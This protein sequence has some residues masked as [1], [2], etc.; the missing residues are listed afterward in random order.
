M[1]P[2]IQDKWSTW[3]V[4]FRITV[5]PH[6]VSN[7][8]VDL[9]SLLGPYTNNL[10]SLVKT[11][12]H[13]VIFPLKFTSGLDFPCENCLQ[14]WFSFPLILVK[15]SRNG[16]EEQFSSHQLEL[17]QQRRQKHSSKVGLFFVLSST[18]FQFRSNVHFT[19][20]KC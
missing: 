19:R 8:T 13:K 15:P 11:A 9:N 20:G 7:Q 1:R 16:K 18:P 6:L 3:V 5:A 2:Y 12:F 14:M 4:P 17:I 10:F